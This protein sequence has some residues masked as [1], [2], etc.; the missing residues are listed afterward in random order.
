MKSFTA[1]LYSYL[2]FSPCVWI[3]NSPA[4][5]FGSK[6]AEDARPRTAHLAVA[7]GK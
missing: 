7:M 6:L 2:F 3:M 1:T 4:Y 5:K